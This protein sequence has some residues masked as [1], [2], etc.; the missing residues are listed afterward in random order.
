MYENKMT[1]P[2]SSAIIWKALSDAYENY[3]KKRRTYDKWEPY[4]KVGGGPTPLSTK[5]T[6]VRIVMKISYP[7]V[8]DEVWLGQT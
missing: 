3:Y 8:Q 4:Q 2:E 6:T 1:S 5:S 7:H